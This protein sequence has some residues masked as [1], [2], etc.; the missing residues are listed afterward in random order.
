M[1]VAKLYDLN[2]PVCRHDFNAV[3]K[4]AMYCSDSCRNRAYRRRKQLASDGRI[5]GLSKLWDIA[6]DYVS[7]IEPAMCYVVNAMEVCSASAWSIKCAVYSAYMMSVDT[8]NIAEVTYAR[9][10]R[11]E[12]DTRYK[13]EIDKFVPSDTVQGVLL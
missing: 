9:Q 2:C 6:Y 4:A 11:A 13:S 1:T 10:L 8:W 12:I 7:E 3:S 5:K